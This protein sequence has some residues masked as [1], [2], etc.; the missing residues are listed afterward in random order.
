MRSAEADGRWLPPEW[1]ATCTDGV[2]NGR[3]RFVPAGEEAGLLVVGVAGEALALVVPGA[4]GVTRVPQD[5][6]DR[7]RGVSEL[8]FQNTPATLLPGGPAGAARLVDAALVLLAADAF[9]G[10]RRALDMA[11]DY[12]KQREQF[13]SVIGR[14]QAIKHQLANMALEVEPCR[15]LYWFAAHAFD[16]RPGEAGSAAALAKAHIAERFLQAA[17][18]AV[19]VHGGVGFT[20]EYDI[21]IW[22][23][24]AMFDWAWAGAPRVHRARY[25]ELVG[26]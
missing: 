17:R 23:K 1:Q 25:A 3:K 24:R 20:W 2:L 9:G 16:H 21:Q 7:T 8:H 18:D 6:I 26:W 14:F 12:A 15:A 4:P 19:E 22:L 13:G 11:V 10:A 5:G